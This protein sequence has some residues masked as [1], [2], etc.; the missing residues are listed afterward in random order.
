M[1]R[2][3]FD[4]QD[5]E[6]LIRDDEGL[7]LPGIKAAEDEAAKTLPNIARDH[8]PDGD[9]QEFAITVRDDAGHS[10]VRV[11]LAFDVERLG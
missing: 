3:Y 11:R 8:I 7:D 9:H 2:Y 6:T 4:V 10:L 5:N 1:S